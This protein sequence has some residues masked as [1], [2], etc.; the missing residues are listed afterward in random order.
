MC[1]VLGVSSSGYYSWCKRKLSKRKQFHII[2]LDLIKKIHIESD[3][4][5]GSTRIYKAILKQG[6]VCN[7]KLIEKLMKVAKIRSKIVSGFKIST[8]NSNHKLPIAPNVLGRNF[9]VEHPGQAWVSDITYLKVAERWHYLTVILDLFNREVVGWDIS[10]S[11]EASSLI[12]TLKKAVNLHK[13]KSGCIFH[14]DRGIQ[15]ACKDFVFELNRHKMLQSMSRRGNCWDNAVAESFFK[16]L[17]AERVKH[18]RYATLNE[19]KKI[20]LNILRFFTTEKE[21]TLL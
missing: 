6:Y 16:T 12:Q 18:I 15:Y 20:Y 4:I 21:C 5:Y 10:E 1:R 7:I 11:L 9:S 8:T 14:S 19:A 2:L 17:K 13:P 3:G